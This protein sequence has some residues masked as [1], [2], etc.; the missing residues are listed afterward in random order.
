[1]MDQFERVGNVY[2]ANLYGVD[3]YFVNDVNYVQNILR[4]KW[5]NYSKNTIAMKRIRTLTG[6]GIITSDG[7]LWKRQRRLM[8]PAFHHDVISGLT[9]TIVNANSCLLNK[10]E[11]AARNKASV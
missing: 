10:W 9:D 7:L 8:Q 5:R 11:N 3:V 4:D 2:K 1:M 6:N